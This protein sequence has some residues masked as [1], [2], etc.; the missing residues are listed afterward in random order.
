MGSP[1]ARG[2]TDSRY[3]V[4]PVSRIHG[5]ATGADIGLCAY[6]NCGWIEIHIL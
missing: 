3:P 2:I 5:L 4:L 1:A 6:M